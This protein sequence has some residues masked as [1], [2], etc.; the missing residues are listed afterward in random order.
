RGAGK[1]REAIF[2]GE[3][4][5]GDDRLQMIRTS[6][7][8]LTRYDAGDGE[9]YDLGKDP[10]ELDNLI[11]NPRYAGVVK[12]LT[13]QL[14]DWDREY[15]NADLRFSPQMERTDPQRCAHL[16]AAFEAWKKSAGVRVP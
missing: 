3:G 16:R 12:R 13:R 9:L 7:W 5:E 11:E 6:Q 15:P 10:N 4:Y 8:E 2:G 14:E 1:G